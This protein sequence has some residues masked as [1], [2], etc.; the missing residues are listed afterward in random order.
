MLIFARILQIIFGTLVVLGFL[1]AAYGVWHAIADYQMQIREHW[2]FRCVDVQFI[3]LLFAVIAVVVSA[4]SFFAFRKTT[5]WTH[6]LNGPP[7]V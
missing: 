2:T 6:R 7:E 3:S 5:A 4:S 1:T